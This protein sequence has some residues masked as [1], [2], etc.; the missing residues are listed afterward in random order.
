MPP[1]GPENE[2]FVLFETDAKDQDV[3]VHVPPSAEKRVWKIV[4][5]NVAIFTYLHLGFLYG[6][7]LML[8]SRDLMWKTRLFC[9]LSL[10]LKGEL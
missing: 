1:Q 4:W 9:K 7:Y 8:T 3:D 10:R 6:G 5:R 2:S